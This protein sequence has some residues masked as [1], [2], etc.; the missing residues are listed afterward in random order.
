MGF[1]QRNHQHQHHHHQNPVSFRRRVQSPNRRDFK[2]FSQQPRDFRSPMR[3]F[4]PAPPRGSYLDDDDDSGADSLGNEL[5]G[6]GGGCHHHHH[7][8]RCGQ[9]RQQSS[10]NRAL[11]P[12]GVQCCG[13]GGGLN[14]HGEFCCGSPTP[15]SA[16]TSTALQVMPGV[17][18]RLLQLEG[19]KDSLH[20]Q[21]NLAD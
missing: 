11:V 8:G 9:P 10:S 20:M 17:E 5:N 14:H 19:D 2:D 1:Q 6:G 7:C 3:L 15:S 4:P 13:V 16:S 21:V 18:E 12:Y